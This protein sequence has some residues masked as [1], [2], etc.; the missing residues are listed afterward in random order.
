MYSHTKNKSELN[1]EDSEKKL[2][3]RGFL[4]VWIPKEIWL[5]KDLSI[6]AKAVW[7]EIQSLHDDE[8]GG[9]FASNEY[10]AEFTGLK[11]RALQDVLSQLRSKGL[12]KTVSFNG[13]ERIL[14]A[15]EP[16]YAAYQTCRKLHGSNAENCTHIIKN[17]NKESIS[18]DIPK[19]DAVASSPSPSSK[20]KLIEREPNVKTTQA[21]H[22]KLEADF[23]A[24][25]TA[26]A[27]KE[28]SE[29]KQ[30]TAR[31]Q[32]K[33]DDNLSIR[34]WGINAYYRRQDDLK[35]LKKFQGGDSN[36]DRANKI[37]EG[38]QGIAKEKDIRIEVSSSSIMFV[39][40]KSPG[41]A[42]KT[43]RYS[44]HGFKEQVEAFMRKY[45]LL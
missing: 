43:F 38:F 25:A 18:K 15:V 13:R 24:E 42:P 12:I 1:Q 29:W 9:C 31:R 21:E 36:R 10:L 22:E 33:K 32:W 34:K 30:Q 44:E 37:M 41:A 11:V 27:Y 6:T 3:T 28:L 35:K 40:L 14:Q 26:G 4:G 8:K 20:N 45:K 17:I 23:G 7:A 39:F 2:P 5:M 19:K 16:K